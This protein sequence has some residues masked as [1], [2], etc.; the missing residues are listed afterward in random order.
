MAKIN[1]NRG[2]LDE[3][4]RRIASL[5]PDSQRRWGKMDAARMLRHL[6]F[7]TDMS[8]GT[9]DVKPFTAALVRPIIYLVFFNLFTNWPK[10]RIKA[11]DF[12]CPPA[13]GDFEFER[14][15]LLA[16]MREFVDALERDP[17]RTT[18]NPGLGPCSMTK[19]SRV[20][21]VH[22]DHHLRQFGV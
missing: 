17:A 18:V 21:G 13:Q 11:P 15:L 10:G 16:R 5:Q 8:L 20:H 3:F 7:T 19:W 22:T 4:A 6:T 2:T 14:G 9:V 12:V 1:L